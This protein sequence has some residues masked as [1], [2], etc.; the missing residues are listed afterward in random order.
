MCTN[1]EDL[2]SFYCEQVEWIIVNVPRGLSSVTHLIIKRY[3][4][5]Q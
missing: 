2:I 1:F 5:K 4:P 3:E